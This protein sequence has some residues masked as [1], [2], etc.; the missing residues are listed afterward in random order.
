[1]FFILFP[2]YYQRHG[3]EGG[4]A[5]P[6]FFFLF[7]FFF[8]ADRKQDWPPCKKIVFRVGNQFVE[9]EKQQQ[10]IYGMSFRLKARKRS[11]RS[12]RVI[13]S[14]KIKY[15]YFQHDTYFKDSAFI[16]F[17]GVTNGGANF[18]KSG[19]RWKL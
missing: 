13:F 1:M 19:N 6:D 5:L 4:Q 16:I 2:P 10:Y 7:I 14:T 15:Y 18:G 12:T 11:P 9:C 17:D 8:S 3:G